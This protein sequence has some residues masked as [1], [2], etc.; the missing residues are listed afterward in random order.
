MGG[1][2][3]AENSHSHNHSS[4]GRAELDKNHRTSYGYPFAHKSPQKFSNVIYTRMLRNPW[5]LVKSAHASCLDSR[6]EGT[7]L[8]CCSP[9]TD[10]LYAFKT[11][12]T[13]R[14]IGN[15]NFVEKTLRVKR[16]AH[17]VYP[18]THFPYTNLVI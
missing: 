6:R 5:T 9:R 10:M 3:A 4:A 14:R 1:K 16:S 11:I 12:L 17:T 13:C 8:C 18:N 7:S 2:A 15:V